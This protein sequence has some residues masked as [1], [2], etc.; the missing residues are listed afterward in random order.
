MNPIT[1]GGVDHPSNLVPA[2]TKCNDVKFKSTDVEFAEFRKIT[3][4]C[5]HVDPHTGVMCSWSRFNSTHYCV[6]HM[7]NGVRPTA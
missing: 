5:L 1:R 2:C 4:R 3:L 6:A 7:F